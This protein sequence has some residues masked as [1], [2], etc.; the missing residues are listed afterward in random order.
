VLR[1]ACL[2]AFGVI[3]FL[4]IVFL[5]VSRND[6][7]WRRKGSRILEDEGVR[8]KAWIV[9]LVLRKKRYV[10]TALVLLTPEDVDADSMRDLVDVVKSLRRR[11]PRGMAEERVA[12]YI[13]DPMRGYEGGRLKI[14]HT[15]TDDAEVY[16]LWWFVSKTDV[17]RLGEDAFD[18][19]WVPVLAA[20][21]E[22]PDL[23]VAAPPRRSNRR[24]DGDDEDED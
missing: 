7:K 24:H 16:A 19:E 8:T 10:D 14:P 4:V 3:V 17:Q 6:A 23:I 1:V 21:D 2:I 22:Y 9:H 20:W 13:A 11:K 18:D 12:E 5:I 15:L